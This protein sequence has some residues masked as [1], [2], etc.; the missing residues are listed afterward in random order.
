MTF[1]AV[2]FDMDGVLVDSEPM[3]LQT[4][5]MVLG[6]RG[7]RLDEVEYEA[8]RGM[9]EASFFQHLVE[10]FGLDEPPADLARERVRASLLA[11]AEGPV[12]PVDGALEALLALRAEGYRLAL[13]S[14]ATR[15]QVDLVVDKLGLRGVLEVLVSGDEVARGKPAGD[16]FTEAARRLGVA[17][18]DCLVVEDAELGVRAARD[19]GMTVVALVEPGR[20]AAPHRLAGARACL[21]SLR[22]LTI[23]AL[24]RW[25]PRND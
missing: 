6:R 20:D 22:E 1:E 13:A 7:A 21:S 23:E 16:V 14:S 12:L 15:Q 2:I 10:R 9:T 24:D 8:C 19:A 18:V 25:A 4:T 11:L 3:H 17:A 5:N